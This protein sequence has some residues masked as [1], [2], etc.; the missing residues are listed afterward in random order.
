VQPSI[1]KVKV[2]RNINFGSAGVALDGFQRGNGDYGN[3]RTI[4]DTCRQCPHPVPCQLACP[5]DAIEVIAPAN[6][7]VVNLDKCAGC[8]IC[9]QACPWAM[10][11]LSGP[12]NA[13]GTH[14]TK[15][16]L[17]AGNPEC[18]QACP[19][20]ALKYMPW[21]DRTKD[22]PTRQ[23]VP[24]SLQFAAGVLDTCNKCH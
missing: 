2:N 23:A 22:V 24:A 21:A 16:T 19:S 13:A 10:T 12:V 5:H 14:A 18:V 9:V 3:F 11:S 20:G 17:C 15:C 1:A 8:G 6:A 4:Q 7:R